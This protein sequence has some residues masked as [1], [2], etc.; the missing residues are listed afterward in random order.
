MAEYIIITRNW[1]EGAKGLT[2]KTRKVE[3]LFLN[4]SLAYNM[5]NFKNHILILHSTGK[6]LQILCDKF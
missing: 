4:V 2:L 1:D 6:K 5:V 3:S